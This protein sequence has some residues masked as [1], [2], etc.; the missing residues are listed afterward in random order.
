[1]VTPSSDS[2]VEQFSSSVRA[3]GPPPPGVDHTPT[4]RTRGTR[5]T[6]DA[7]FPRL[8][9][10]P[11]LPPL[12]FPRPSRLCLK[13]RVDLTVQAV[14]ITHLDRLD[15]LSLV[16]CRHTGRSCFPHWWVGIGVSGCEREHRLYRIVDW[17]N[18][19]LTTIL[20]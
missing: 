5:G 3:G 20:R 19:C 18:L 13:D 8:L 7:W 4:G 12:P 6:L 15:H 11:S 1:M 2:L 16:R 17:H 14:Q 10:P 9:S